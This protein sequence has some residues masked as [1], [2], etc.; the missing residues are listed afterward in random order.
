MGAQLRFGTA[1]A[2][3]GGFSTQP[4]SLQPALLEPRH[5]PRWQWQARAPKTWK[6]RNAWASL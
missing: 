4:G 1:G 3:G 5:E 2:T 6:D